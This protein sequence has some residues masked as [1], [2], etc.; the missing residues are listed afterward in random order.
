MARLSSAS[1]SLREKAER[2][3]SLHSSGLLVLPNVWDVASAQS[4]RRAGFPVIATSSGAVAAS[5]GHT[6]D[7]SMP[8]DDAFGVVA[9]IARHV[10]LPVTADV[11]AGYQLSSDELVQR[12]LA[13]GAVGCNLEDTDHH[14]LGGLVPVEVQA[15]RVAEV[16]DAADRAGIPIVVNA[17]VDAF[18]TTDVFAADVLPSAVERGRAYVQAG[19]DCVYPIRLSDAALIGHFVEAVRAP[20]NILASGEA[21]SLRELHRLGVARASLAGGLFRDLMTGL[22]ARLRDIRDEV[23]MLDR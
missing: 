16:R 13:A 19:A 23:E 17:R 9:R 3:R 10:D 8:V 11:E 14:G 7:D 22:A 12:L 2:L 4:V 21:P 18:R 15:S 6:D 5:L 1:R 20:V